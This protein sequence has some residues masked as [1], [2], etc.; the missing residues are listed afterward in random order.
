MHPAGG[1]HNLH[2]P[3][4]VSGVI[5]VRNFE[6]DGYDLRLIAPM[7]ATLEGMDPFPRELDSPMTLRGRNHE[8]IHGGYE[9]KTALSYGLLPCMNIVI[10]QRNAQYQK[11]SSG[12]DRHCS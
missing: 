5:T 6:A 10:K 9:S 11:V 8:Q 1:R 12:M 3:H 7:H 2:R 4:G